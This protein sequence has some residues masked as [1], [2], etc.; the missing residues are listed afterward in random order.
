MNWILSLLLVFTFA[1]NAMADGASAQIETLLQEQLPKGR[2]VNEKIQLKNGYTYNIVSEEEHPLKD[3]ISDLNEEELEKFR[4]ARRKVLLL[5]AK[6]LSFSKVSNGVGIVENDKVSMLKDAALN[7]NPIDAL[8]AAE[9]GSNSVKESQLTE[10]QKI[11]RR[12]RLLTKIINAMDSFLFKNAR[13]ASSSND[14][15]FEGALS[16][17]SVNGSPGKFIFGRSVGIHIYWGFDT[18]KNKITFEFTFLK[19]KATAGLAGVI[20]PIGLTPR[21]GFYMRATRNVPRTYDITYVPGAPAYFT[22]ANG[23]ASAGFT[24][25][26]TPLGV[27]SGGLL[28]PLEAGMS[29]RGTTSETTVDFRKTYA[30]GRVTVR[31]KYANLNEFIRNVGNRRVA[32]APTCSRLFQ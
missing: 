21:V 26:I 7:M 2:I 5:I 30:D 3:K 17:G 8:A 25:A 29:Y 16:L 28:L 20:M 31:Q 1:G 6:L 10:G 4:S 13:T 19:E 24:Q 11:S 9:S 27:L 15:G 18:E 32:S 12:F 23:M 22:Q 14:F